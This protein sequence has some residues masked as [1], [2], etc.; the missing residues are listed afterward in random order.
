MYFQIFGGS[1]IKKVFEMKSISSK[2]L[3][4]I[5][6]IMI[7]FQAYAQP[8]ED[9]RSLSKVITSQYQAGR[10]RIVVPSGNYYTGKTITLDSKFSGIQIVANNDSTVFSSHNGPVFDLK[11][12]HNVTISGFTMRSYDESNPNSPIAFVFPQKAFEKQK[13]TAIKITDSE[14]VEISDNRISGYYYGIFISFDKGSCK[15]ITVARNYV[16]DCGYQSIAARHGVRNPTQA[17][18][19]VNMRLIKNTI[20]RCEQGPVFKGVT[21]SIIEENEVHGNINGIRVEGSERNVIRNNQIHHN[22]KM[23]VLLYYSSDNSVE[24]NK[25]FDNNLQSARIAKIAKMHGADPNYLP[26]DLVCFDRHSRSDAASY[27]RKVKGK[28]NMTDF[29]PDFWPYPTS[30]EHITPGSKFGSATPEEFAKYWG[31]H[32]CQFSGVGILLQQSSS[33]NRLEHNEIFNSKP[34]RM[35]TG[36]MPYAIR[37]AQ[38][39][40]LDPIAYA[41]RGNI[42]RNNKIENMVKGVILDDNIKLGIKA[43]NQY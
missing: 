26:G 29:N 15:N 5:V 1:R 22:L 8:N 41:S 11:E 4:I 34:V 42:I 19:L 20:T 31:I 40:L 21:E 37:I 2:V 13:T 16:S 36:Y 30:Y 32:F 10:K 28:A 7:A 23:G 14:D 17:N 38:L 24:Y 12:V 39:N 18:R 27:S 25:I 3:C 43:D 35:E 9:T 6:F 33:K